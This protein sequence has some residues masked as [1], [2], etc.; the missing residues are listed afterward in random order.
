MDEAFDMWKRGK[1]KYDYHLDFDTWHKK[2]LTDQLLRDR[3]HPSVF[4][5][6]V[7]NEIQEQWKEN[8]DTS[9]AAILRELHGIVKSLDNRP[10][11]T[12]NND[13]NPYN[14]LLQANVT[15][16]IGYNYN[17]DKWNAA[18]VQKAWG[19]KPFIITE[20]V[21][22]LQTRGHYDMPSDSIRRWPRRWDLPVENAN[23]DLTCSAYENCSAP[24]G[25]THLETLKEFLKNDNVSGM[26]I[27]TGFDYIGEPTPYPWPARS[28]YFGIVD[29]AGFPKDAYYLYQSVLTSKPMLHL[30][31][32][33]N[34]K[35]GQTVDMWAYYNNADEV[36]LFINGQ[37]Q[38][39]RS[40]T[41]DELR[42]MWRVTYKPGTVK[43]VA[44]KNGKVIM[45]KEIKTAG[46]PAK[47]MLTADRNRIKANGEDLSFVTVT[48]ADKNGI[49]V[50]DAGNLVTFN[51]RGKGVI[52][53]VDNGL[54]T[55]L[56]SFKANTKNAFN[57]LALAVVQ[58]TN[59]A[60]DI[61]L[62]ATAAGLQGAT[63]VIH[64]K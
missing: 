19:R 61:I 6:S 63:T 30:F 27:W 36:E 33:W 26:F 8:N 58:S 14:V 57:G 28:S 41:G 53:G 51:I 49:T 38:G 44:R 46:A 50:P 62:S 22:A 9:G 20:S 32:H 4:I 42:V 56:S 34:W 17:P 24:W 64:T 59:K 1:N 25:A 18:A 7:G 43:A 21:S 23:A 11:V 31:P 5:W 2:D 39:V 3:N 29:L 13:P 15:D 52:A 40:K 45:M 16:L 10:T 47:I 60:G 35:P 12:A 48:I 37:S 54:Q 55:D